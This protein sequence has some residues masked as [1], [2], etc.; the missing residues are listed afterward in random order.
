[1]AVDSFNSDNATTTQK[2]VNSLLKRTQPE[3]TFT[4]NKPK[5]ATPTCHS[6]LQQKRSLQEPPQRLLQVG[7]NKF[8]PAPPPPPLNIKNRFGSS[9]ELQTTHLRSEAEEIAREFQIV[10]NIQKMS[11]Q[12]FCD[13]NSTR[14]GRI[15]F[16]YDY[17]EDDYDLDNELDNYS[18]GEGE[19][20]ESFEEPCEDSI[21]SSGGT[22]KIA[23]PILSR[24]TS[25]G[26]L[27][28]NFESREETQSLAGDIRSRSPP[29]TNSQR[30]IGTM[31]RQRTHLGLCSEGNGLISGYSGDGDYNIPYN[32]NPDRAVEDRNIAVGWGSTRQKVG[33]GYRGPTNI[34]NRK[35]FVPPTQPKP[36]LP[37][38]PA[39]LSSKSANSFFHSVRL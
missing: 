29:I 33:I 2:Y 14:D 38:L 35:C 3:T 5:Y 15:R 10:N 34:L 37:P 19:N 13:P 28:N 4:D 30:G 7:L 18:N 32:M 8:K 6:L 22:F 23:R 1:M 16:G 31:I 36:P 27:V 11:A 17:D 12:P 9:T 20:D 24:T 26:R 21:Y 25:V 39:C